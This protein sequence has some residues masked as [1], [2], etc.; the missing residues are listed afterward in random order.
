MRE[1]LSWLSGNRPDSYPRGCGFNPWS[2]SVGWRS[3]VAA[4]C[5]VVCRCGSDPELLQLWCRPAAAAPIWP[6]AWEL[7]YA[8]GAKWRVAVGDGCLGCWFYRWMGCWE[9]TGGCRPPSQ[10]NI[11]WR[12]L[13]LYS[14]LDSTTGHAVPPGPW[15]QSLS[16]PI[17]V[18]GW[19]SQDGRVDGSCPWS[20]HPGCPAPASAE[21]LLCF[22]CYQLCSHLVAHW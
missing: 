14:Q 13:C 11:H 4:S 5:G 16:A 19:R 10:E 17:M 20:P 2:C 12:S 18:Y 8:S 3:G 7:P 6:L 1:F 9:Q 21:C 15:P 22:P